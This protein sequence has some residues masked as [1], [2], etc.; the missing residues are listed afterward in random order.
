MGAGGHQAL[1]RGVG[2]AQGE[3]ERGALLGTAGPGLALG[4]GMGCGAF[5]R[6]GR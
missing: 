2:L 1:G 5:P 6:S 3:Q 4:Q